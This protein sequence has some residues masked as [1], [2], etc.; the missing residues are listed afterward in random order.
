MR[1]IARNPKIQS[2]ICRTQKEIEMYLLGYLKKKL[3]GFF[4][5]LAATHF[6]TLKST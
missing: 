2:I 5:D 3:N 4:S 6:R 1:V